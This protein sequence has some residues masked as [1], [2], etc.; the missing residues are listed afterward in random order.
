MKIEITYCGDG[1]SYTGPIDEPNYDFNCSNRIVLADQNIYIT[2]FSFEERTQVGIDFKISENLA[3]AFE[4]MAK[5][6]RYELE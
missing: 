6:I 4:A 5:Q 3:I 2:S 1:D